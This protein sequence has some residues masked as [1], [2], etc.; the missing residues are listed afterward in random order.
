MLYHDIYVEDIADG[1]VVRLTRGGSPTL[2]HGTFDW[3][4]EE[5]LR[6]REGFRFSPDGRQVAF[7]QVDASLVK[8]FTL[9]DN[10][11]ALPDSHPSP[12]SQGRRDKLGGPRGRGFGRRR[13]DSF[14]ASTRRPA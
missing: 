4:Y 12:V 8:E 6:L 9:I 10:V 7:W 13:R 14:H 5:E 2:I 1:R 3:V 11:R